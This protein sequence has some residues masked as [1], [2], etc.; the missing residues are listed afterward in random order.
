MLLFTYFVIMNVISGIYIS[1]ITLQRISCSCVG[2]SLDSFI[3]FYLKDVNVVS[4]SNFL[5]VRSRLRFLILR[6]IWPI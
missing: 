2:V 3:V 6:T 4:L 1:L 5:R